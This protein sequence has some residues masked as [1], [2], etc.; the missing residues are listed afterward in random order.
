MFFWLQTYQTELDKYVWAEDGEFKW[1]VIEEYDF[2][3]VTLYI[4]NMTSQKWIDGKR[5]IKY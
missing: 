5:L 1:E 3:N 2:E 4:V